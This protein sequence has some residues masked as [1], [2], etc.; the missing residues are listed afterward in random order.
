MRH[1]S[2]PPIEHMAYTHKTH[3]HARMHART[4]ARAH[5]YGDLLEVLA[6]GAGPHHDPSIRG[7]ML[8]DG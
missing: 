3:T 1:A 2:A 5:T 7:E 4:R 8:L 6:V